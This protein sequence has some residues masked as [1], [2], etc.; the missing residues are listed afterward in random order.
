MDRILSAR[1]DESAV[2]QIG[3]LARRLR[4]S[5]KAV[6]EQA[7]EMYAAHVDQAQ[8][9]DVFEQTCGAWSREESAAQIVETTR[10]AF[11]DSMHRNR[12]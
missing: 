11:L 3:R 7:I 6:I 8:H 10:Q 5:K 2:S 9:F 1:I 4:T 12:R